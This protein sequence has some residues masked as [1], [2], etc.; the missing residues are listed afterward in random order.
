[1]KKA[2]I[3]L[4]AIFLI[5]TV[6]NLWALHIYTPTGEGVWQSTSPDGRFTVTGYLAPV[7][8]IPTVVGPGDGSHGPGILVLTDN[9]TGQAL[10]ML[11]ID[12]LGGLSWGSGVTWTDTDVSFVGYT[13][14]WPLPPLTVATQ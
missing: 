4:L 6:W 3:V 5:P 13:D 11:R 12:S 10:K 1:M 14:E 7:L 9:Q 2:L 8:E